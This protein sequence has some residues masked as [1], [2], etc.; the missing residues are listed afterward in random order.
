MGASRYKGRVQQSNFH[1][2]RM[3]RINEAPKIEVHIIKSGEA[4]GGIGEAGT[5][6][7]APAFAN[8]IFAATGVRAQLAR[9]FQAAGETAT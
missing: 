8:A 9:R 6:A 5:T 4:P 2:Y 7:A 1:D 3:M